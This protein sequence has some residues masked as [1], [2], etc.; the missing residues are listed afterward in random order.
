MYDMRA[1]GGRV[2]STKPT[3]SVEIRLAP[4]FGLKGIDPKVYIDGKLT[5]CDLTIT[6]KPKAVHVVESL[7]LK[8]KP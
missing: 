5:A 2:V 1:A 7:S 3:K 4:D 6:F 8:V